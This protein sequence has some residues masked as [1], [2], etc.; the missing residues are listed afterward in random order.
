MGIC[1]GSAG[2]SWAVLLLMSA[3]SDI[4]TSVVAQGSEIM[5]TAD[6]R[7]GIYRQLV[8]YMK[9]YF[10]DDDLGKKRAMYFLPWHL[11][12]LCRYRPLPAS[13]YSDTSSATTPLMQAR[14]SIANKL[15][16]VQCCLLEFAR[17]RTLLEPESPG[18]ARSA[19]CRGLSMCRLGRMCP[20]CQIWNGS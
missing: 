17:H 7:V 18:S 19:V 11:G 2:T 20:P 14:H 6:E 3:V 10:H 4:L 13:V 1:R 16:R 8:T 12:F 5:P 9:E 15:V